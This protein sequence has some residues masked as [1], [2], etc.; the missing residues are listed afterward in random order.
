MRSRLAFLAAVTAFLTTA[1]ATAPAYASVRPGVT[2]SGEGTFYGATGVGNCLYDATSDIAI[3]ALNHTDYEGS[4]M[5]GAHLHVKGPRG[6]LTVKIVDRCPECAPGD[7]DLG[8]QAF[9]RIADPVAG[10]VPITWTLVSPDIGGPVA[11]R[12]KEGSTQWWCGIQVRSHRNPV[13][14]LEVRTGTTWRQLP[15]QEYNYFVS[16][17]GTG[18]GSDIRVTDIHGQT[19][20]DTG[21]TITPNVDQP[22]RAQFTKR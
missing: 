8:Q 12:Y 5:C 21:I 11:Y 13:A 17:D 3:A 4:R 6:E 14:T 2:Y 1:T 20:T 19:L 10:R 22:G 9:A 16:A 18:C 7:V 15:R